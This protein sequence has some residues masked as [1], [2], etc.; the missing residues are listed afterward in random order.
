M[1][2]IDFENLLN[3]TMEHDQQARLLGEKYC[4]MAVL[5]DLTDDIPIK[6]IPVEALEPMY[7]I[8]KRYRKRLEIIE[9]QLKF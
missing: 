2:A 6:N 1:S 7:Q 3:T 8:I 4:L 9:T 5:K